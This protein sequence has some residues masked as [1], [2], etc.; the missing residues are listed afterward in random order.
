M[1]LLVFP[2]YLPKP[3]QRPR[4]GY[5]GNVYS[6]SKRAEESLAWRIKAS[7]DIRYIGRAIKVSVKLFHIKAL[8]GD[9]DNYLKFVLDALEKST[10]IDNDRNVVATSIEK[11]R[12]DKN[13][14]QIEIEEIDGNA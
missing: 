14:T 3:K 1:I 12:S 10:L 8:R 7:T 2:D 13:E 4:L 6:P 9:S 11:I 5:R